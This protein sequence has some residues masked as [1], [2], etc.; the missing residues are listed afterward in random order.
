MIVT[1]VDSFKGCITSSQ[2]NAAVAAGVPG[3]DVVAVNIGDGGEG[4][5]VAMCN[6]LGGRMVG[7]AAVN[8]IGSPIEAEYALC[9]GIAVIDVAATIGLSLLEEYQR[10]P[11]LTS[12]YGVGMMILD[13]LSRG[14]S[15]IYVALGGSATNDA[16]MG[17]LTALGARFKDA[18]GGL[19]PGCGASM[20]KVSAVEVSGL[21]SRLRGC[22]IV[23]CCD[24]LNPALGAEGSAAVFGGQKGADASMIAKLE[25]GMQNLADILGC[26]NFIAARSGAAGGIGA[27]ITS[28]L[29]GRLESGID[30]M[31]DVANFNDII[32]G[33][34]L[35][36]TGEGSIDRQTLM[37]KA[38]MGVLRRGIQAGVPV[39]AIAGRV[40]DREELLKAGFTDI[41]CINSSD[42][43]P[44]MF[45]HPAVAMKN[46]SETIERFIK[47]YL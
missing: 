2:A 7:C 21:D 31:L 11:W 9:G 14:A 4:T 23:G 38:P 45:M 8:A 42:Y 44:K 43:D 10:N 12:S 34:Q 19:L 30:M 36:I 27:A 20:A 35:I 28:V 47:H 29:G 1:A 16:G 33:A 15:T 18:E 22:S 3:E 39:V 17:M 25:E 26:E 46:I 13:A 32:D 6:A 41:V 24:V 5:A 40:R 37:G